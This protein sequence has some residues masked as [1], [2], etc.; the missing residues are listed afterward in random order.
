[1][2]SIDIDDVSVSYFL[3]KKVE[4]KP[5]ELS[6]GSVGASIVTTGGHVEIQALRN[7]SLQIRSGDRIGLIG[8]NGSG[9]STLLQLC[10]GALSPQS[11]TIRIEGRVSP[12]FS[13]GAGIKRP[14]SGRRNAELKCLYMGTPQRAIPARVEE[15]KEL[16]GLGGFFELPVSSYSAGMRSRLVMSMLRLVRAEILVMDEW[17]GA[18]DATVNETVGVL[19]RGLIEASSITVLASHSKNVLFDWTD[20]IAWLHRGKLRQFGP[21][22]EVY[23]D[24]EQWMKKSRG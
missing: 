15:I 17:I 3:R 9:K 12:Q 22:A 4:A 6:H 7:I 2:A 10:A 14:L 11:G 5:A 23:G 24:Y 13:L 19:K 16:S 21:I 8:I 1:M 18:A 20:K